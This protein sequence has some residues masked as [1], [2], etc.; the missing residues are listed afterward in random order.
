MGT[1]S[2]RPFIILE[3]MRLAADGDVIVYVE[4]LRRAKIA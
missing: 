4:A 3:T 2:G 1:L